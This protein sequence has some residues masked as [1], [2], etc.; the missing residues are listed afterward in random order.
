MALIHH[1][2]DERATKLRECLARF[3][4]Y[5]RDGVSAELAAVYLAE[6]DAAQAMLDADAGSTA[7]RG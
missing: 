7:P 1:R 3:E 6:I 4:G 5:L 2:M